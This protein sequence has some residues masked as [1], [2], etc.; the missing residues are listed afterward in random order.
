MMGRAGK[1][2]MKVYPVSMKPL[3]TRLSLGRKKPRPR[4][5]K[6]YCNLELDL[7]TRTELDLLGNLC[8]LYV[9]C[10]LSFSADGPN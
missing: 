5:K 8:L 3:S 10:T 7:E 6:V 9:T 2:A 4:E 1:Q